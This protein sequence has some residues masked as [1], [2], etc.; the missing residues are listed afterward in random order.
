M[1]LPPEPDDPVILER[2]R[3]GLEEIG[4]DLVALL[5][6]QG[7]GGSPADKDAASNWLGRRALV[8][9]QDRLFV[10]PGAH[11]AILA[12]LCTIAEAGDTSS[13]KI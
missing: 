5:R 8:P 10:T 6:Y 9:S 1:N 3:A 4:G 12:I 13:A 11:P 2:M 7:F